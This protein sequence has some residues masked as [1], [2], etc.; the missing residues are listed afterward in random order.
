MIQ[1]KDYIESLAPEFYK[2]V[3]QRC[4]TLDLDIDWD[5]YINLNTS[6]ML[7]Y[8][9]VYTEDN[10]KV[11]FAVFLI[12][13]SLH[14]KGKFMATS[15]V[16]YIKPGHRGCGAELINLIID[17]LRNE[18]VHWFSVNIKAWLDSGKLGPAIGCELYEHVLQRGL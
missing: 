4:S 14:N 12:G 18:G 1:D 11:G 15:D 13:R 3:D 10:V 2:E 17:D 16:M 5:Q 8:Y 6:G 7:R 9:T